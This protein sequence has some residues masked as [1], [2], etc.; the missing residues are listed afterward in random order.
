ML[1]TSLLNRHAAPLRKKPSYLITD[2][3]VGVDHVTVLKQN[4]K[5][6]VEFFPERVERLQGSGSQD[7]G[8]DVAPDEA[9]KREPRVEAPKVE[10]GVRGNFAL[11]S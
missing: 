6:R 4:G 11:N 3:L 5:I 8:P 2:L 10:L 9:L 1:R 7:E